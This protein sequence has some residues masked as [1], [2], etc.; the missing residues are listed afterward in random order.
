MVLSKEKRKEI[1]LRSFEALIWEY[2][3]RS[4]E[5]ADILCQMI[6]VDSS[7]VIPMWDHLISETEKD[8]IKE[9]DRFGSYSHISGWILFNIED[10]GNLEIIEDDFIN[11][12]HLVT[13]VFGKS[14]YVGGCH[15][16]MVSRLLR[17]GDYANADILIKSYYKNKNGQ[18][19]TPFG[20]FIAKIID[21][22]CTNNNYSH[23]P[24]FSDGANITQETL[25]YI[26][27]W[28]EDIQDDKDKALANIAY[29]K[30]VD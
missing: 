28:I 12:K 9:L 27:S 11:N 7:M 2:D 25:N 4:D 26:E 6:N 14:P 16:K 8:A 23:S 17:I 13:A 21:Y 20:E 3:N 24:R 29:L 22:L 30:I 15:E 19:Y 5:I 18:K 1:L 10:K